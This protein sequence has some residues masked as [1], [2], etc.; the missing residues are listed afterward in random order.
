MQVHKKIKIKQKN[1]RY[2]IVKNKVLYL[3]LNKLIH[4]FMKFM[5]FYHL[6]ISI[7][8]NFLY[9]FCYIFSIIIN[10]II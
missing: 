4:E 7:F 8:F 6:F 3:K 10:N 1:K 5:I 9:M 2:Q